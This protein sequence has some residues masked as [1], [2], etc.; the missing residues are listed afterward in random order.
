MAQ[1]DS[2]RAVVNSYIA[3]GREAA[4]GTYQSATA[5]MACLEALSCS[6]K[7]E[8]E[9]MKIPSLST[10]RG[11]SRRVQLNKNVAGTLEQYLHPQESVLCMAAALGG[12]ISS[13]AGSGGSYVHVMQAGN[14][15]ASISSVCF[16]LRKASGQTWRYQG[17]RVNSMKMTANVGEPVKMSYDFLFKDSTALSEDLSAIMTLTAILPLTYVHGAYTYSGTAQKI[18][19]FELSVNNNFKTDKDARELGSNVLSVMPATNRSVE[20]KISQRIDTTTAYDVFLAGTNASVQLKFTSTQ[21]ISA[22]ASSGYYVQVDLAKVFYNSP[23]T[24]LKGPGDILTAEIP[25]DV[26]VDNPNTTTGYDVKVT[27]KNNTA[28]YD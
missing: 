7:T 1:G 28:S 14:F 4:F 8:I 5:S 21:L 9:S 17:G 11:A 19:G 25:F 3:V 10:N 13:S 16:N 15:T 6:F 23:D 22:S 20:F 27:V 26:M 12:G 24:E 18:Q 2:A